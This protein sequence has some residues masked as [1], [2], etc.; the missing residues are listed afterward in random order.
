MLS[1]VKFSK[2]LSHG[3]TQRALNCP[4]QILTKRVSDKKSGQDDFHVGSGQS[5]VL[6]RKSE[7]S[8]LREEIQMPT[9]F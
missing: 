2:F 1:T 4:V 6:D 3:K 7:V 8:E 5:N 9:N